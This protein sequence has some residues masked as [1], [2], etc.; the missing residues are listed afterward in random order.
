MEQRGKPILITCNQHINRTNMLPRAS[1]PSVGFENENNWKDLANVEVHKSKEVRLLL[2]K[3]LI[4]LCSRMMNTLILF[5]TQVQRMVFHYTR[6]E[7]T[8]RK[9]IVMV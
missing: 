5:L 8:K 3:L 1:S 9:F 2:L 6:E 4:Y 7:N